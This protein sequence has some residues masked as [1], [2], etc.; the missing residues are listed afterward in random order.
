MKAEEALRRYA[1]E[2]DARVPSAEEAL[3]RAVPPTP[4]RGRRAAVT[5]GLIALVLIAAVVAWR[6]DGT[7]QPGR[8][9]A[10]ATTSVSDQRALDE[11]VAGYLAANRP[12][13]ERARFHV[14]ANRWV[15]V[16]EDVPLLDPGSK[17]T[18]MTVEFGRMPNGW[19]ERGSGGSG[20]LDRCFSGMSGGTFV[21]DRAIAPQRQFPTMDY[22]V[23]VAADSTWR[24]QARVGGRWIDVPS[25][26]GVFFS[27][28]VKRFVRDDTAVRE[29]GLFVET[30][31]VTPGGAVAPCWAAAHPEDR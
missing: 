29:N 2:L 6:G 3:L 11:A 5:G 22:V 9:N 25:K 8:V 24:I 20:L 10:T 18:V 12:G 16:A 19:T 7:D 21:R 23:A 17:W 1:G 27:T 14:D 30:R 15:V 26:A 4:G 28:D 13:R 31:P